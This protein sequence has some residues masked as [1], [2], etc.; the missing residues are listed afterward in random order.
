MS[1]G[2]PL[3]F[4][5]K[6]TLAALPTGIA[7]PRYDRGRMSAG[8]VHFGPGAFFRAHQASYF[9]RLVAQRPDWAICA[10]AL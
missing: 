4:L 8:V 3:R 1:Q 6:E 10:V 5:S 9:E 7:R 2:A